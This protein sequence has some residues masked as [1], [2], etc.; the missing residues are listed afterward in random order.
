MVVGKMKS[1][2]ENYLKEI[3]EIKLLSA[4]EE[5]ELAK[6][7]KQNDYHALQKLVLSNLRFVVSV[8][9]SYHNTGLS[10]EDLVDEG[11]IGLIVAAH[12]Y[13]ETRGFKFISYAVW[14]IRQSILYAIAEKNRMIRLPQNRVAKLTKI[15]KISAQLEQ[16]FERVPTDEEIAE[17]LAIAPDEIS[18]ILEKGNHCLSIDTSV[19][20]DMNNRLLDMI[21]NQNE[22]R[23][24]Y[25]VMRQSLKE[26]VNSM[27]D[28][29]IGNGFG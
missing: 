23:P 3:G 11:N 10:L 25:R 7:I 17:T 21:E 9:K 5:I 29:Q 27:V 13:D 19:R 8:A 12:H 15:G 22:Q 1:S 4:D 24:D 18:E 2:I 6:R 20:S 16:E 26:E 28:A 14:W